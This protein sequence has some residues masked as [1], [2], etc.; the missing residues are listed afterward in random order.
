[1]E[2]VGQYKLKESLKTETRNLRV[3]DMEGT[4]I[5]SKQHPQD[6]PEIQ[7]MPQHH[8]PTDPYHPFG[9]IDGIR[10]L[11]LPNISAPV[12][13]FQQLFSSE[14]RTNLARFKLVTQGS[15]TLPDTEIAIL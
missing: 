9:N 11:L 5:N 10:C 8:L 12:F 7:K 1:M 2:L 3:W 15:S 4:K 6:P 14:T 13:K